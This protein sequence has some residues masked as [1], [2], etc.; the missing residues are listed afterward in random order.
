MFNIVQFSG[1][2][3]TLTLTKAFLKRDHSRLTSV[4]NAYDDGKS[5]GE[6]RRIFKMLGPSDIRKNQEAML[7][8]GQPHY[9]DFMA[10]FAY[11]YPK[12]TDHD[13]AVGQLRDFASGRTNI[14]CEREIEEDGTQ[15]VLR[16]LVEAFVQSLSRFE[17]VHGHRLN[18]SDC[19]IMNCLYAGAYELCN[20][21]FAETTIF[22]DRFFHIQ[23]TVL[24]TSLEDQKLVAIRQNYEILY[25]EAEIVELRA[26]ERIRDLFIV[27]DYPERRFLDK[28]QP[29]DR[30]SY[31][32][33][34]QARV[35]A[36][37]EVIRAIGSADIL[38]YGPGTQHSSLYPSYMTRGIPEAI[39]ANRWAVKIFVCNIG[40]DYETPAYAASE[41][42]ESA[43]RY[44][45]RGTSIPISTRELINYVLVN[46]PKEQKSS[47]ATNY[48]HCDLENLRRIRDVTIIADD[49]E[50][51]QN[52]G[53]HDGEKIVA[54]CE[55]LWQE[56]LEKRIE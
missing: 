20:R 25:S 52:L 32:S 47:A 27:D 6:I 53:K 9:E 15:K 34:I 48:I 21:D 45:Q 16:R 12:E 50:D 19:S 17:V 42:V 43:I 56:A 55:E 31:L 29:A 37:E 22:L 23:G 10:L 28:L 54:L 5:T 44:L 30:Y 14:I 38:V 35:R 4:V 24:P 1:G 36:T 3:G 41:L 39:V 13:H 7:I 46:K 51:P 40:E 8:P 18:F 26:N 49:F 11:R 33:S 2:R